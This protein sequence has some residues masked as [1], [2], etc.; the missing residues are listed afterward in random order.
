MPYAELN[1]ASAFSF[2]EGASQP[3][4]LITRAAELGLSA[5]ALV[6]RNGVYGAP[7]F[8][9]AARAAGI[10]PLVG[11][12]VLLDQRPVA[13]PGSGPLGLVPDPLPSGTP[14]P[15]LNLL[16]ANRTGYRNL[17]RLLTA[18]AHGRP[19]GQACITWDLLE[20][21]ASG[22]H[23]LTGGEEGLLAQRLVH[24]GFD[25]ARRTV[26][27]LKHIFPGRLHLELQRHHRRA[28]EH[29]NRACCELSRSFHLPLVASNGVRYASRGDKQLADILS[30]I[31]TGV[32]LDHAAPVIAAHSEC[33]LKSPAE[34]ARLFADQPRAVTG[35]AELAAA[36]E[37]TLDDLGYRFPDSPLPPGET[38]ASYLRQ[39]TWNGARAR[40]RPLT[41]RAQAQL[42]KELDL[43]EKLGL[44]GYFL[45][46]EDIV[47]FCKRH[48]ILAQGRGSAANSAVCYALSITAVD[49]VKMDLLFERFLSEERGE[50]P[51]IDLDLPSGG[52][53]ERVIQYVYE[54]YGASGAA[55]T[56]NVITY[57]ARSAAREVG[58]ALGFSPAQVDRI[59]R[60]F[61]HHA[62]AEFRDGSRDL[63]QE[64]VAAGLDPDSRRAALFAEFWWRIHHLPRH[65]GQHSGGMVLAAGRLDEIVPLEP[66]AMANR[67]VIQWDKDDCADL[68]LIKVDLLG[69]GMLAAL[70]EAIPMIKTHEKV[71]VDLAHLPPDD[72]VVYEMIR[73]ADTAGVFQIESRGQMASLPRNAPRRFY[74]LV[75]Q[76]AI[77]RPGPIM[78]RMTHPYLERRQGREK[79]TYPHPS[80][81][82]ILK[83][84][85]GI[86][87]FQEQLLRIAM[88]A[89]GFT[90]GEAEELRRAMGF[91]RSGERM[92][93]IEARL[94][95]GMDERGI[96]G[97]AQEDI[98]RAITSFALYGFPESHSASFALIVYASAYLK[99]HHPT[100]FYTSLFNAWPMGFYHPATLIKD[101]QR[102]GVRVLPVDVQHSHWRCTWED[103][104]V[105]LGLGYVRGL[106][107][108]A[109]E[110]IAEQRQRALFADVS[111]L[112]ERCNLREDDL[113]RLAHVGA[114]AGFGLKRRQA[115]WQVAEVSHRSG[116]LLANLPPQEHSPLPEMT[117]IE[118]TA[119]DYAG[120][121]LTAGPH[122]VAHLRPRLNSLG[123][124]PAARLEGLPDGC[125][126]RI[127]GTVIVRQRPGSAKGVCFITLE[128]D[129]GITQAIV[130]PDLFRQQRSLIVGSPLLM[131]EG[132]LQKK[133]G[134]I[135]VRAR[136][137]HP[138]QAE[139]AVVSH[140]FH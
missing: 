48:N 116:P 92:V 94:R 18:G 5:L 89:A 54:R 63:G 74:D 140:D 51:D 101:A 80:L 122:L 130:R 102:H 65:L 2:L 27:N 126:V 42:V 133:D 16:V 125:G 6:D 119:A 57:R 49:P 22:L 50:W 17:C 100:A 88:V 39:I 82:P 12:Q 124:I 19:K 8:F 66:A 132:T 97:A 3:E 23:C 135:S 53:R 11:A 106:V 62:T 121:H 115:L 64:L 95:R 14:L 105:R 128:D 30:C 93:A 99:A 85:L 136:K 36:L 7:R 137:L 68:G 109:G 123:V 61:G 71:E 103:G 26:Q 134:T 112:A 98:V 58:K 73:R 76:V 113:S 120:M 15:R 91:K 45:I 114:L 4:D 52:Q 20:K 34:M 47:R 107:A 9:K 46:V 33:H 56:A 75:V 43:I 138:I 110:A 69:L 86:P 37:F 10:R 111:D 78:G 44:A 127:A 67:T 131:V 1:L 28:E 29:R 104:A 139:A 60:R 41:S 81:E 70:E 108:S 117:A 84:T 79:V 129:T 38:A 55:M 40:F 21:Y 83:R 32:T 72:P 25:G 59:A 13:R 96:K 87:I 118:E 77:I 31:R 90:G 24:N 35:A